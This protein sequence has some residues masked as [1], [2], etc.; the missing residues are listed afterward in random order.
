MAST[1]RERQTRHE[2]G[3]FCLEPKHLHTTPERIGPHVFGDGGIPIAAEA[4]VHMAESSH[5]NQWA[6]RD[7]VHGL[8][9]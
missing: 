4:R 9:M 7:E 1:A 5:G 3:G 6:M 2:N 8:H